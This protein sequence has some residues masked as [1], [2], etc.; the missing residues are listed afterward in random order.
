MSILSFSL[1]TYAVGRYVS[2]NF[3]TNDLKYLFFSIALPVVANKLSM[4]IWLNTGNL[5]FF[6]EHALYMITGTI[7][8]A[9]AGILVFKLFNWIDVRTGLINLESVV[10]E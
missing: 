10:E 5:L 4:L 8:T 1:I 3:Y 6:M 7:V 9:G 2:T